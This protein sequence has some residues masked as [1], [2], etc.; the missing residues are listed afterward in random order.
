MSIADVLPVTS[1]RSTRGRVPLYALMLNGEAFDVSVQSATVALSE[2]SHDQAVIKVSSATLDDT[3]GLVDSLLTFR[4]GV[5]PRAETFTGYIMDVK[6]D[7]AQGGTVSLSFT[8][9]VLGPT[10]VMFEGAPRFWR[11]RSIPSAVRGLASRNQLG[12]GG[13]DHSYLWSALAQTRESDWAAA[14]AFAKRIGWQVYN[15]YGVLLCYDPVKLYQESGPYAR[16]V[17]GTTS[18][19][20]TDRVLLDFQPIEESEVLNSN[21]GRKFGY[22][23]SANEPQIATQPGEFRGYIFGADV[24]IQDQDAAKVYADASNIDMDRW[25]QYA[26]ARIWGDSDL[27]PGMCVEIVS[28]NKQYLKAKYDGKWLIRGAS[29][30]MDRQEYQTALSL[31]RPPGTSPAN[32]A[33]KPFWQESSRPKPTMT[34]STASPTDKPR[35]V[36]SWSE[37]NVESFL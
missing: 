19:L 7:K 24:V 2:G 3:E 25:T 28:T 9:S 37:S 13:H 31:A 1:T 26:L 16:L 30:S 5:T 35:W 6:E 14:T 29:H 21:L 11:N 17:M 23:T 10:K 33:Y 15:R 8:M 36:S 20:E 32:V 27:Y 18:N 12:Y 22:F 34:K 4:W